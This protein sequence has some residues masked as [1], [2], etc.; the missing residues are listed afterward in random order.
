MIAWILAVGAAA[1]LTYYVIIIVYSGI[2]TSFA[3]IWLVLGAFLG[4]AAVGVRYYQKYP[5]RMELWIPVSLVTL[6]TSGLV[7]L[8]VLQI[9]IFGRIPF[10][11]EPNLDYVI[12]LGAKVKPEGVSRILKLRLDKAAEYA[13]ENPGTKLIL[14]GGQGPGEPVSEA[15]AMHAYLQALGIP[16]SQMILE[17][18]SYSTVENI[19]NSKVLIETY[20]EKEKPWK[21][22][23][24]EYEFSVLGLADEPVEI[25]IVT[26]NFHLYRADMIAKKQGIPGIRGIAA[27]S[28]R[29]LFVHFCL[30]DSLAI[31][32]DRL[33]GN[34]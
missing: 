28:D 32:K 22:S 13:L 24:T 14:S 12:V 8:L 3:M 7:I 15:L 18:H 34:L 4:V 1:C 26:S 30:R 27:E 11:A 19:A 25:G 33:M 2:G 6:C 17:E 21:K 23:S 16:E 5:Q 20:E 10:T 9:L 31:L 29:I